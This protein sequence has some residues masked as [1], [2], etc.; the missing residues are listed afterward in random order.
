MTTATIECVRLPTAPDTTRRRH[1]DV[2]A[3]STSNALVV[4][5]ERF[6]D[7]ARQFMIYNKSVCQ[8]V[9]NAHG[10]VMACLTIMSPYA[11]FNW[12]DVSPTSLTYTDASGAVAR[13]LAVVHPVVTQT[14]G[15]LL[16]N[17][18]WTLLVDDARVDDEGVPR[19]VALAGY[20]VDGA[21]A[22]VTDDTRLDAIERDFRDMTGCLHDRTRVRAAIVKQR[23]IRGNTKKK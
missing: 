23:R 13:T 7:G 11:K 22:L 5:V 14:I 8:H 10:K 9:R 16:P 1:I 20:A 3:T 6:A 21:G 2:A 12:R 4:D 18:A 15:I 17:F 19:I